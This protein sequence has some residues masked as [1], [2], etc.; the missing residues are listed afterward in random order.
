MNKMIEKR[1]LVVDFGASNVRV[2]TAM[3]NGSCY[4][5]QEVYRFPNRP[6]WAAGT[7]YWD[8]LHL[9]TELKDGIRKAAAEYGEIF[10]IG[11]DT[12]G[13]D[14]GFI[15]RK[16][17]LLANPVNYRDPR[18]HSVSDAL[19]EKIDREELFARNGMFQLTIM[20][21]FELVAMNR[22]NAAELREADRFLM[23]PDLFNY[24]LT[25]NPVNE[26]TNAT[27]TLL[28]NAET[29]QWDEKLLSV[30]GCDHR[31]FSDPVLPGT[32]IG[33]IQKSVC[34]EL[35]IDPF[36]VTAVASHD[37]ASAIAGIPVADTGKSWAYLSLGTW[38]VI[39]T[40]TKRPILTRGVLDA[41]IGNE[42]S[43]DG[44]TF[45]ARNLTALWIT[46]Q[47]REAWIHHGRTDLEWSEIIGAAEKKGGF[48]GFIDV[49]DPEFAG[50]QTDMPKLI[51][52]KCREKGF[53]VS[54]DI[55]SVA[56]V[57]YESLVMKFKEVLE[58]IE[59][60]AGRRFELLHIIGGGSR[61]PLLCQWTANLLAIPVIAGPAETTAAGNLAAQLLSSGDVSSFDEVRAVVCNSDETADYMP[62]ETGKW[63]EGYETYRNVYSSLYEG[64]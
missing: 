11:I 35:E 8:I 14:F 7:L 42:G 47:C 62:K 24:F 27:T 40:V 52:T 45:L 49:D 10:S 6:V 51:V 15:D 32:S 60:H 36:Q 20:S 54:E 28:L 22:D 1:F 46:Q 37:T 21:I 4:S 57:V 19:F 9:L 43:W 13:V 17:K 2:L 61:N 33:M 41:G 5:F 50:M 48:Q 56:R 26:Y 64:R 16:G 44:K 39:G 18:R 58:Q 30:A 59:M 29:K 38:G 34:E 23:M 12:W 3:F 31:L 25:G 55:G 63:A 53:S